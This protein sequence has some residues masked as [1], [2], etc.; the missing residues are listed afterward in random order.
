MA[1]ADMGDGGGEIRI[2]LAQH[3]VHHRGP[4]PGPLEHPEGLARVHRAE[5]PRVLD[6]PAHRE[7]LG[8]RRR[9]VGAHRVRPWR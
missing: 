5:L 7:R 8:Q 4:H 9:V 1:V 2:A 3:L 6:A